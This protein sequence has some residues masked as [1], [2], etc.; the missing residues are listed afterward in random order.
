MATTKTL[1]VYELKNGK[2]VKVGEMKV[3]GNMPKIKWCTGF[4]DKAIAPKHCDVSH[5]PIEIKRLVDAGWT[6]EQLA[7]TIRRVYGE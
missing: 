5:L 1:Y 2:P 4:K 6:A 3:D 7:H